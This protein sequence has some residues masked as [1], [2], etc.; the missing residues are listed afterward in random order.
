MSWVVANELIISGCLDLG[1][2]SRLYTLYTQSITTMK[3]LSRN[4]Y[5]FSSYFYGFQ[6]MDAVGGV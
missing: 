5:Y 2:D 4:R 1:I 6:M 3:S